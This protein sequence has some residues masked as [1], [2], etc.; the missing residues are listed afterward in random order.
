[1][2]AIRENKIASLCL[3]ILLIMVIW[4]QFGCTLFGTSNA[5]DLNNKL[6]SDIRQ[7][8]KELSEV[9]KNYEGMS[10]YVSEINKRVELNS[11][12]IT[13]VSQNIS[14]ISTNET[15]FWLIL[16]PVVIAWVII[17][18]VNAYLD[19][20]KTFRNLFRGI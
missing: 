17:R 13:T 1:M 12:E 18:F 4:S 15:P 10:G 5:P 7:T 9:S 11:N 20:G 19:D 3:I 8:R 14:N 6:A 16:L 2:T